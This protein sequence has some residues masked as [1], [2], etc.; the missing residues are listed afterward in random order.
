[1]KV[2][3]LYIFFISVLVITNVQAQK[4]KPPIVKKAAATES[5]VWSVAKANDWYSDNNWITGANFIPSTAINQLEM[6]QAD[7]FDPTT[8]DKELGYAENI[9][10]NAMRV[11]LHS[12]VWQADS[13]GFKQRIN[14]YLDISS[15]HNIKTIFVFFD[16]CWNKIP[17]PGAQST[18]R[19]GIHNSGWV[20]DPGD[21]Y[22]KDTTV[23]P[24]LEKYVKSVLRNFKQDKRILMWDLYNEPGN[25]NKRDS[26]FPL[27]RKVFSWARDVNPEQPITCGLWAWDFYELNAFQAAN[28]DI[29]TY[30]NYEEVPLHRRTIDVLKMYG[31]PLICTE[32]MA[33]T[34]KS[35]FKDI[36][37]LLKQYNIGAINWGLVS[38][39]TNTIYAWDDPMEN[40]GEPKEWFHDV[41]RKDGTPYRKDETELIKKFTSQL[42]A[43]IT[44]DRKAFQDTVDG[45]KTDL[46]IIKNRNNITAVFTNYG[47]RLVGLYVPDKN[48]KLT[49][50][51]VG[52]ADRKGYETA[53]EPYFGA[54]IGRFGNRIAKGKFRLDGKQYSLAINNP[55]NTLHG[56]KKGFQYVVWDA[57][58]T[59][60]KTLVLTYVSKD[61]EEGFPGKLTVKV[62]Y[63]LTDNNELK[64]DYEAT[65]DKKTVI[66]LTNHAFFNLNGEGSGTILNHTLMVNADKYTPVD[67]T[68]IPTGEIV[69]VAGTPFDFRT[70]AT[71]GAK[72]NEENLQLHNGEGYDHNFVLNKTSNEG[73]GHAATVVGDKSGIT[74]DVFTTEPGLQLY[75]GNFMKSINTFKSGAKDDF[76]TAFCMETQHFPDSPN[77][78]QFPSTVLLPG[79]TYKTSSTYKF[80]I[81]R[82]GK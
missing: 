58:Q 36:F 51:V 82:A 16:D 76:R 39:K 69:A 20:Q 11:F 35:T 41:F 8:I 2:K 25:G 74:M 54:T 75:S 26:S 81:K 72:I 55:P 45:K 43:D 32:Y 22:S 68:L 53:T 47:G 46:F 63:S 80:T 71:I 49:D 13:A 65:T 64:M 6:W 56:G 23:Y 9:G 52:F 30:H 66:N 44:L 17:K 67:S 24:R 38:G 21:P 57:K 29:I 15:R 27:L 37:P 42:S 70:P 78:P 34:R 4:V 7:S 31:R 1:M 62:T 59:N 73:L 79:K 5:K 48:G 14:Q 33:R 18:P 77:Q 50:V 60:E 12:L 61:M 10:F 19:P 3:S 28:S 40:G